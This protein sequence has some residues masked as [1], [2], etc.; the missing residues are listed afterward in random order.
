MKYLTQAFKWYFIGYILSVL[1]VLL[2]YLKDYLFSDYLYYADILNL[3]SSCC[4]SA[5]PFGLSAY[6]FY[7]SIIK[8]N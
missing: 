1:I 3:H 5:I 4:I 7:L 6:L 2:C 8:N